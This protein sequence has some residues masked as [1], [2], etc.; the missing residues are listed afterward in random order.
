MNISPNRCRQL[1]ELTQIVK[2]FAKDSG[3]FDWCLTNK[4]KIMSLPKKL[5]KVGSSDY[6]CFAVTQK[7]PHA[8]PPSIFNSSNICV[9]FKVDYLEECL[10][11]IQKF[12]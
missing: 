5:P 9:N 10:T 1:C 4:P 3:I 12:S 2:K 6:Y 8:K 11:H 7:L